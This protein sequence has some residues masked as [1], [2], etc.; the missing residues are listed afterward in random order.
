MRILVIFLLSLFVFPPQISWAETRH[1]EADVVTGANRLFGQPRFS[2]DGD[3]TGGFT[4]VAEFNPDGAD[5]IPLTSATPDDAILAS[6]VD[7]PPFPEDVDPALLNVPLRDVEAIVAPDG[8]T[9]GPLTP[10]FEA[11]IISPSQAE[12]AFPIT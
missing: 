2:F 8:T 5:P 3:F 1:F 6:S 11:P 12:P 4:T 7:S 10:H 9:R